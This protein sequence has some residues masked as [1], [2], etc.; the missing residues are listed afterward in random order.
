MG[1][2]EPEPELE[3]EPPTSPVQP[4]WQ[5]SCD[6]F[7]GYDSRLSFEAD[8]YHEH[9]SQPSALWSDSNILTASGSRL[10]MREASRS[11]SLAGSLT[12]SL[13]GSATVSHSSSS[14]FAGLF[15]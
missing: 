5:A 9:D 10:T 1:E 8:R 11:G 12:S 13:R 2:P 6:G 14:Y 4:S 15:A 7:S 3:L